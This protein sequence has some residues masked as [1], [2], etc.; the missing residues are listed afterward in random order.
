[1]S[2]AWTGLPIASPSAY[3]NPTTDKQRCGTVL[4][5]EPPRP[6]AHGRCLTWP[7]LSPPGQTSR[8]GTSA[9]TTMSAGRASI[10]NAHPKHPMAAIWDDDGTTSS[11]DG[12]YFRAGGV[13][14]LVRCQCK[15]RHRSRHCPL[16]RM[17]RRYGPFH[18]RVIRG[19]N[20]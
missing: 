3:G 14:D 6:V 19:D 10:I 7:E 17:C 2:D 11:S 8:N 5:T 13:Q 18:T 12:Q 1:M 20:E 15:V 9:T 4:A 16:T